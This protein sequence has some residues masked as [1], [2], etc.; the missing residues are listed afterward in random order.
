MLPGFLAA[1]IGI[2][3]L[4]LPIKRLYKVLFSGSLTKTKSGSSIKEAY[5]LVVVKLGA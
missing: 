1:P 4:S 3:G 2:C 5:A